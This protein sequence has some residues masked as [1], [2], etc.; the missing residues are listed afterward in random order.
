MVLCVLR[1]RDVVIFLLQFVILRKIQQIEVIVSNHVGIEEEAKQLE[2]E[3]SEFGAIGLETCF[4]GL[5]T[6]LTDE[7][8]IETLINVLAIHPRNLLSVDPAVITPGKM[9]NITVFDP[10]LSWHYSKEKIHSKSKNSPFLDKTLKGKVLGVINK[11]QAV[12]C[13]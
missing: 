10:D 13:D 5:R 1:F 4:S 9:A 7:L 8:S 11:N 12:L 6:H 3:Y 2:F